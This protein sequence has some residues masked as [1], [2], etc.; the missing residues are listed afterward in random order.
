MWGDLN[1]I[2]KFQKILTKWTEDSRQFFER[3]GDRATRRHNMKSSKKLVSKDVMKYFYSTR[4]ADEWSRMT[5]NM[6]IADR[7]HTLK[8][9]YDS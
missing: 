4:V 6:V 7:R 2:L 1:T 3:C 5:E 8:R 9:L